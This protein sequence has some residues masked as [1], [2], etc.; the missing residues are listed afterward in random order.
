MDEKRR[1]DF[2]SNCIICLYLAL[3]RLVI[4]YTAKEI[5]RAMASP[6]VHDDET[7]RGF[8]RLELGSL[9][10]DS[11]EYVSD[12]SHAGKT[13]DLRSQLNTD[14]FESCRVEKRNFAVL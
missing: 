8:D 5:S 12:L 14:D 4:Q 11:Q 10:G 2:R 3:D 6:T 1:V 9:S 13:S 7:L